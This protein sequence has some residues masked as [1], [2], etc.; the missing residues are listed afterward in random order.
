MKEIVVLSGKGGT[1]KTTIT[2]ALAGLVARGLLTDCDVDAPNLHLILRPEIVEEHAFIAGR[3][4]RIDQNRCSGCGWCA[5]HCRFDAIDLHRRGDGTRIVDATIN[6][7]ACEGCGVCG[8]ICPNEA[9]TYEAVTAGKWYRSN[10]RFGPMIHAA[11][12]VGEE[13]S[14]KLVSLLRRQA[15]H[16]A[17]KSGAEFVLTDGA[18]GIGCPVIA[19]LGGAD[20][21][22]VVVEP[23]VSSRHDA[24][25]VITLA[26]RFDLPSVVCINRYDSSFARIR[27]IEA[28]AR[29]RGVPI[30]GRIPYDLAVVQAQR[31]RCSIVEW[32]E[33]PA[34]ASIMSLWQSIQQAL[35]TVPKEP[36]LRN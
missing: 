34:A 4:A 9:I 29:D 22:V 2:A 3:R 30:V 20:L 18:P 21:V 17:E 27:Q 15:R 25:R 23:S 12:G 33:G 36:S 5:A 13:N 24:E 28:W 31:H 19:S 16:E 6:A 14:G 10:T 26:Q 32:G 35:A 7:L 11:L 8:V 1:G